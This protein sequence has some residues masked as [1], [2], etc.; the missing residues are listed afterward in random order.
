MSVPRRI[1]TNH[2]DGYRSGEWATLVNDHID[3]AGRRCFL[4]RFP[5]GASDLWVADDPD[6]EYEFADE[7]AA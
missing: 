1:R 4:V 6:G 3:H 7:V 5:D 2:P